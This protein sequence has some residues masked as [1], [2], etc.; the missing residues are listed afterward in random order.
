VHQLGSF[1]NVLSLNGKNTGSPADVLR[2][3]SLQ[4]LI[5]DSSKSSNDQARGVEVVESGKRME[6]L[7]W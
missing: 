7:P 5:A 4:P 6:A 3:H 1:T 2:K